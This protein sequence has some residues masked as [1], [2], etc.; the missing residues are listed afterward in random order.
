MFSLRQ[1]QFSLKAY[2]RCG[3]NKALYRG[4]KI[5][6]VTHINDLLM[7]FK[8]FDCSI[9]LNPPISEWHDAQRRLLSWRG[10]LAQRAYVRRERELCCL[11]C[12]AGTFVGC[13]DNI[14]SE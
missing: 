6:F 9:L 11:V 2:W 5:S 14:E 12:S 8:G 4:T 10:I 3:R 13:V 1:G 7:T